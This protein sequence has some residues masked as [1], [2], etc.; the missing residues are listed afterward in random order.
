MITN[1]GN[2]IEEL[3]KVVRDETFTISERQ[4]SA[5]HLVS[6]KENA[7]DTEVPDTDPELQRLISPWP[8]GS[9]MEKQT[10]ATFATF[11]EV[12]TINDARAEVA[13]RWRLRARLAAVIDESLPYLERLETVRAILASLPAGNIYRVNNVSAERLLATVNS[14][15]GSRSYRNDRGEGDYT[16]VSVPPMQLEDVFD[17]RKVCRKN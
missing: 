15:T 12:S 6:L 1:A 17:T 5:V 3:R 16:P 11:Q 9:V 13:D 7:V 2:A 14:P 8:Q 10:T 4:D